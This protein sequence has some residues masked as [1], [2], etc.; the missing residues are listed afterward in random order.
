[1]ARLEHLPDQ[2]SPFQ[3]KIVSIITSVAL[4]LAGFLSVVSFAAI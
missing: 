1:M 4:M 2:T 3:G